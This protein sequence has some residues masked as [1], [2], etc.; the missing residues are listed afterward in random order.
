[1]KVKIH[2]NKEVGAKAE[3]PEYIS[4]K[5]PGFKEHSKAAKWD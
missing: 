4:L 2:R 1:M 5:M 3:E